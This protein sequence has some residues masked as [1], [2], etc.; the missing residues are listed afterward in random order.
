MRWLVRGYIKD[1]E[2]AKKEGGT[3][4]GYLKMYDVEAK[5]DF[6]VGTLFSLDLSGGIDR[7]DNDYIITGVKVREGTRGTYVVAEKIDVAAPRQK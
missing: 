2:P 5:T 3:T 6:S 1:W 4:V 7:S